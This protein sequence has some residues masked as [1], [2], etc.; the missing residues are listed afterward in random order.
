MGVDAEMVVVSPTTMTDRELLRLSYETVAAFGHERFFVSRGDYGEAHH[1]LTPGTE[2]TLRP[3]ASGFAFRT[4]LW[5]S[6]YGPGYERGDLPFLLA[7]RRWFEAKIPGCAVYYG[8]DTG[9]T[10]DLL[11]DAAERDLWAH[12]VAHQHFP[13]I[14]HD[15]LMGGDGIP[16]PDCWLC[17]EPMLRNGFG[18]SYGGFWCPGC[19]YQQETR[20][21]GKTWKE[22]ARAQR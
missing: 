21:G 13:Y 11:D 19:G 18:S 17:D 20:D 8:G 15:R 1:A 4:H 2:Y 5:S 22:P 10:L 3:I 9:E 12:F 7:L 14:K 6:Y 16:T